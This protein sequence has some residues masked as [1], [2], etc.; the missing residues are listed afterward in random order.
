MKKAVKNQSISMKSSTAS[1][2]QDIN[3]AKDSDFSFINIQLYF[4]IILIGTNWGT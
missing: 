1:V 4:L 3:I 2:F